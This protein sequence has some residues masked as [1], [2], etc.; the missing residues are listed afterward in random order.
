MSSHERMIQAKH[1]RDTVAWG[2]GALA[3]SRKQRHEAPISH[4]PAK[5]HLENPAHDFRH[6][7][8]DAATIGGQQFTRINEC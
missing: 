6:L 3:P 8:L 2:I 4:A 1:G 5:P 7:P